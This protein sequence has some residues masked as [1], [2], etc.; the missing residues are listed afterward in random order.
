METGNQIK[1]QPMEY[2]EIFD[3]CTSERQFAV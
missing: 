2:E 3:S 1:M